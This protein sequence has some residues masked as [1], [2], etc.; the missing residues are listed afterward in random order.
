[1]RHVHSTWR[2]AVVPRLLIG[3]LIHNRAA[4]LKVARGRERVEVIHA[5][6]VGDPLPTATDL[7]RHVA[8]HRGVER[9]L[10]RDEARAPPP[11]HPKENVA[12]LEHAVSRPLGQHLMREAIRGHQ[13]PSEAIRAGPLGQHLGED[14]QAELVGQLGAKRGLLGGGQP[15]TARFVKRLV[16]AHGLQ[17]ATC[18][19][20]SSL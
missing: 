8:A 11:R 15:E 7:E 1:M 2:D 13:R 12:R 14:E 9:R 19:G 18:D 4:H 17:R 3:E 10:E 5:Q 16:Q 6:A 20:L